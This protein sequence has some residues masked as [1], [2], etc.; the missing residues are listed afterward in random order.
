MC[1]TAMLYYNQMSGTVGGYVLRRVDHLFCFSILCGV[2]DVVFSSEVE[3]DC[4]GSE[5]LNCDNIVVCICCCWNNSR[6]QKAMTNLC[7]EMC[8]VANGVLRSC[9]LCPD[10]SLSFYSITLLIMMMM[11]NRGR[12]LTCERERER[13][14]DSTAKTATFIRLRAGWLGLFFFLDTRPDLRVLDS[15]SSMTWYNRIDPT[16]DESFP[17]PP[18]SYSWRHSQPCSSFSTAL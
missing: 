5:N 8:W 2:L 4:K 3:T 9:W 14:T 18:P 11:K 15:S 12:F 13:G 6:N 16:R 7:T 17:Y 1:W 10:L